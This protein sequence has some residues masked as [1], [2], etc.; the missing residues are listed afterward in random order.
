LSHED[1]TPHAAHQAIQRSDRCHHERDAIQLDPL[2]FP[3]RRSSDLR[4]FSRM[5]PCSLCA[6]WPSNASGPPVHVCRIRWEYVLRFSTMVDRK[7]TRLN[8]SHVS[9]SYA[10]FCL[11]KKMNCILEK[12]R[13]EQVS[14]NNT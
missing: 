13:E 11:K 6:V 9:I 3:T 4:T 12:Q 7:S 14:G 2:S 10:V 8:S 5:R 1:A